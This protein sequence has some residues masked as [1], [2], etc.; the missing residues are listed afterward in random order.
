[1]FDST[2]IKDTIAKEDN[3]PSHGKQDKKYSE[4]FK[5]LSGS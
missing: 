1:M 3:V 5:V 4:I 2:G